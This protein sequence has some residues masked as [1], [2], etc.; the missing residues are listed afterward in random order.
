MHDGVKGGGDAAAGKKRAPTGQETRAMDTVHC[1]LCGKQCVME[2]MI[3]DDDGRIIC[4]MC[5][6]EEE[7]CGC[8]GE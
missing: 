8:A 4:H 5:L 3:Y 2:E 6:A 1:A 7:S